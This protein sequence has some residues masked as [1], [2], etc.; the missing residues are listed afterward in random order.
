M[1]EI[2]RISFWAFCVSS[3]IFPQVSTLSNIVLQN[4]FFSNNKFECILCFQLSWSLFVLRFL[5]LC[6]SKFLLESFHCALTFTKV[7]EWQSAIFLW[8]N[9]HLLL[10]MAHSSITWISNHVVAASFSFCQDLKNSYTNIYISDLYTWMSDECERKKAKHF[11]PSVYKINPGD[12][13]NSPTDSTKNCDHLNSSWICVIVLHSNV[14]AITKTILRHNSSH[15]PPLFALTESTVVA[16]RRKSTGA[17]GTGEVG[18]GVFVF[19]CIFISSFT[20]QVGTKISCWWFVIFTA[21]PTPLHFFLL[22]QV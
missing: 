1:E 10:S 5:F 22:N 9:I 12:T 7:K 20:Q 17:Y 6:I 4:I 11:C 3:C 21:C 13:E 15:L 16:D 18:S 8:D 14:A 19:H 2:S